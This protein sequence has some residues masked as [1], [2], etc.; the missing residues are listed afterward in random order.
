[1]W[2]FDRYFNQ[3]VFPCTEAYRL[4][5]IAKETIFANLTETTTPEQ[6]EEAMASLER[7]KEE[8]LKNKKTFHFSALSGRHYCIAECF[9][10][11]ETALRNQWSLRP[12]P[13]IAPPLREPLMTPAEV[14][15][16]AG[17]L[18]QHRPDETVLGEDTER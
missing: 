4:Q 2:P 6:F 16:D 11:L 9:A 1:M 14:V 17:E 18:I 8:Q 13:I 3:R 5:R 7:L 15:E 10:D 12:I